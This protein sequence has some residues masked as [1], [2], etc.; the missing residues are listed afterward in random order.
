MSQLPVVTRLA[1][2]ELW[3]SFRLLVVLAGYVGAGTVVALLPA[4]LPTTLLRLAV[5]V[6]TAMSLGAIVAAWSL[7]RERAL[8]RAGRA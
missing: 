4:P 6:A 5:G 3:I 1:V 8:G 2:H 7:S